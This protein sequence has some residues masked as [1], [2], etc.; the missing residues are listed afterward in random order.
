MYERPLLTAT[1]NC[2]PQMSD[3]LARP[4]KVSRAVGEMLHLSNA[5]RDCHSSPARIIRQTADAAVYTSSNLPVVV[6]GSC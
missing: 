5:N 1:D 4:T 3:T 2:R 6:D